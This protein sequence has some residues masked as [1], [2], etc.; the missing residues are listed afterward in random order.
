[1]GRVM[2]VMFVGPALATAVSPFVVFW[3]APPPRPPAAATALR[4]RHP[5]C[6]LSIKPGRICHSAARVVR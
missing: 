4:R 2:P 1:M 6:L 3:L 5:G